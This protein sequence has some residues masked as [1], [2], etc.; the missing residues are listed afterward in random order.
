VDRTWSGIII[1]QGTD[2]VI[3]NNIVTN[4]AGDGIY[5]EVGSNNV[6][7]ENNYLEHIGDTAIDIA[8]EAPLI[9]QNVVIRNNTIKDGSLRV[10]NAINVQIIA[11]DIGGKVSID[12]GQGAPKNISITS[13]HIVSNLEFGIGFLGAY[14]C[15]A[16]NNI[17]EM[18]STT[19]NKTQVGI[20]AAIWGTGTITNN[21]ITNA[22]GYGIN[23]GGYRLGASS[24]IT[25]QQ[26]T[27]TNYG[28][29][30]IYDDNQLQAYVTLSANVISS[31]KPTA[32]TEIVTQCAENHWTIT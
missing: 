18:Q 16:E 25:I 13:N 26:N 20:I 22:G 30:G 1:V 7:I 3:R 19:V 14:N 15:S 11:N 23:F 8:C 24:T 5:P 32:Q 4:T 6:T 2:A 12:A 17:I 9:H 10:T 27:I 29:Y 31:E 28:V 21:T